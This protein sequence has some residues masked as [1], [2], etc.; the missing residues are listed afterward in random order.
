MND[1]EY[2]K[3][4]DWDAAWTDWIKVQD[5]LLDEIQDRFRLSLNDLLGEE[6]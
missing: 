1:F 2:I 6:K 3:Q 5:K 4:L